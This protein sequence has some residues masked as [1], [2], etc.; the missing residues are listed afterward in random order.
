MARQNKTSFDP[1]NILNQCQFNVFINP[2]LLAIMLTAFISVPKDIDQLVEGPSPKVPGVPELENNYYLRSTPRKLAGML[3][4]WD[5]QWDNMVPPDQVSQASVVCFN[6]TNLL[7]N[8]RIDINFS[9]CADQ[10]HITLFV[11]V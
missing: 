10:I 1:K 11:Y 4:E 2:L 6:Y 5:L 9:D 7:Y 8:S 3:D